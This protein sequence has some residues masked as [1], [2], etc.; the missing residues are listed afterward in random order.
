[1]RLVNVHISDLVVSVLVL[2]HLHEVLLGLL[3]FLLLVSFFSFF[4]LFSV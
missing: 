1:L 4:L 3:F 2:K